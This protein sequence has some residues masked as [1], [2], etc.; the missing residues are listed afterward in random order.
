MPGGESGRQVLDRYLPVI[1]DLRG[2]YLDDDDFTGDIVVV[3]HG[4]AIR[5]VAAALTEVA[6]E[7]AI[8]NQLANTES[9][10]LAPADDGRWGCV[11]WGALT[12]PFDA[13]TPAVADAH[14]MG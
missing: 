14:P 5:L 12:P 6:A 9:V 10:V 4:A 11:R 8:E 13:V 1:A 7:F 3:S 2:R